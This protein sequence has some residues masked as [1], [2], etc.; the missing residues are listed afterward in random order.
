MDKRELFQVGDVSRLFHISVSS[1]RHYEKLGLV[2]LEYV[3]P[4]T[5][6]RYYSTR[7][8]E[9]LNTIR[10]L[11][12]LGMPLPQIA[13]FLGS[14]SVGSIREKLR[15]QKEEVVRRQAELWNVERKIDNRLRQLEDALSSKKDVL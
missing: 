4:K 6:Y 1:L 7:Q 13:E 10:Y 12:V 5:G 14:R 3:D 15:R 11:R 8:F 2:E 9:C